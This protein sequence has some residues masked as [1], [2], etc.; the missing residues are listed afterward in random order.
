MSTPAIRRLYSARLDTWAKAKGLPVAWENV[1]FD[2]PATT[3]LRFFILPAG[4][5]SLDLAGAHRQ[6]VGL[7]QAT[8]VC[9]LGAGPAEVEG[10]VEELAELFPLNL[11]LTEG[12]LTV[13]IMTPM[14]ATPILQ[15][16]DRCAVSARFRYQADTI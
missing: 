9:P 3:Y 15:A 12:D 11:R 13:Q 2:P 16:E 5:D 10:L 4:V 6:H 7:A 1:L 14:S 8:I